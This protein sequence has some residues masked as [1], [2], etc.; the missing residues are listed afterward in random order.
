[1]SSL[2]WCTLLD[3]CVNYLHLWY[4]GISFVCVCV[5]YALCLFLLRNGEHKMWLI[6][7]IVNKFWNGTPELQKYL[8]ARRRI[9]IQQRKKKLSCK[10]NWTCHWTVAGAK[11]ITERY[12]GNDNFLHREFHWENTYTQKTTTQKIHVFSQAHGVKHVVLFYCCQYW[13]TVWCY[14]GACFILTVFFY[15]SCALRASSTY[16]NKC[17]RKKKSVSKSHRFCFEFDCRLVTWW[18]VLHGNNIKLRLGEM[19]DSICYANG[20]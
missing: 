12:V 3:T 14:V 16:V 17:N 18:C 8:P 5:F 2:H 20:S 10:Q 11:C 1:M 19:I 13:S 6:Q 9:E 7:A 15:C 4:C